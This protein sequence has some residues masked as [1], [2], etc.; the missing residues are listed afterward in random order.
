MLRRLSGPIDL[1]KK[2]KSDG[3]VQVLEDAILVGPVV[4]SGRGVPRQTL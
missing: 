1:R 3:S 4:P 2:K